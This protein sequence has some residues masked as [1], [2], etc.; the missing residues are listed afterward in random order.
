MSTQVKNVALIGAS[1]NLGVVIQDHFLAQKDS[2]LH[3]SVLTRENS[4]SRARVERTDVVIMLLPPESTVDHESVIDAAVKAG[5]K[6]FF[7]SEYGVRTYHPAFADSVLLATKKRSIVKHLEKTQDIMSWTGIICNPWVDFCVIDGL[8]GFDMKE[9]KARIYNGGDVPFSTGLRDLAAQSLYALI[10]NPERL[11]EAKNQYIHVA[12]YTVTQNEI[13]DVVKKL[14][15]QE[16]QVENATSEGVMPEALEDIKK[17]LNW[18][19]GHQVQAILF[20]YDSEGH[21]IGDF[22]PLGIWNEKL[23][24][25]KST[26]EQ[27]LK[28]PLTGDWK[29]FVHRQP[30]ELP[31]YE[32]KRDRHRSTGL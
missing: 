28:G 8:L 19:L 32:L 20:S 3:L 29:G 2:P 15:G 10:T 30:D 24:L 9:R 17:G 23:G 14:T 1:G 6:R 5:V 16:W 18:G 13:L 22:R 31:N 21:G 12:S 26:L 25:S 4:V 27:D 11:E 7:P